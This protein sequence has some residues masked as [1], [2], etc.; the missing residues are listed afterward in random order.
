MI[1]HIVK[2]ISAP[3]SDCRP[4]F[5][6]GIVGGSVNTLG[7]FTHPAIAGLY[8]APYGKAVNYKNLRELSSS[9][10]SFVKISPRGSLKLFFKNPFYFFRGYGII[11]YISIFIN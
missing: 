2:G 10:F 4:P 9:L 11:K 3:A 5:P 7:D 6:S 1:Q 8:I